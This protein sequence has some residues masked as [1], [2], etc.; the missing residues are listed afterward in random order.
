LPAAFT[1]VAGCSREMPQKPDRLTVDVQPYEFILRLVRV[2]K[3][4]QLLAT[5]LIIVETTVLSMAN[6]GVP[7]LVIGVDFGMSQTGNLTWHQDGIILMNHRRRLL[8]CPM[9][10]SYRF[11]KVVSKHSS[12]LR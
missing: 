2:E 6:Y 5:G 10:E 11:S 8:C 4:H 1:K 9:D 7:E 3:K 12:K